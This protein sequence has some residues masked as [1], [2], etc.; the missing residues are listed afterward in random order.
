MSR[1]AAGGRDLRGHCRTLNPS[2]ASGA[3]DSS[4]IRTTFSNFSRALA[5]PPRRCRRGRGTRHISPRKDSSPRFLLEIGRGPVWSAAVEFGEAEVEAEIL[6]IGF[7]LP[8]ADLDAPVEMHLREDVRRL[9]VI[10]PVEA[11]ERLV[12]G[13]S[14]TRDPRRVALHG[15]RRFDRGRRGGL[16][17]FP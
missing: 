4:P 6:G 17:S 14:R 1:S 13:A 2:T 9:G 10:L 5:Y 15:E 11:A 8:L 16:A 3:R 12:R 7:H